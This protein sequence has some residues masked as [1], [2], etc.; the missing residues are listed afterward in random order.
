MLI[1]S[2]KCGGKMSEGTTGTGVSGVEYIQTPDMF[3]NKKN[4]V[5]NN[6]VL[7]NSNEYILG[8]G[9]SEYG[10]S[11][12]RIFSQ[13]KDSEIGYRQS[14]MIKDSDIYKTYIGKK[15]DNIEQT[16]TGLN[17]VWWEWRGFEDLVN[18]NLINM[19]KDENIEDFQQA[20]RGRSGFEKWTGLSKGQLAADIKRMKG[21]AEKWEGLRDEAQRKLMG[22]LNSLVANPDNSIQENFWEDVQQNWRLL[23][24]RYVGDKDVLDRG[25][26]MTVVDKIRSQIANGLYEKN[27]YKT[28][29]TRARFLERE[30]KKWPER[31]AELERK[32][33]EKI[34]REKLGIAEDVKEA[35]ETKPD[36]LGKIVL[37]GEA[38]VVEAVSE[39]KKIVLDEKA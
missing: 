36:R 27:G 6:S 9:L 7:S 3:G 12:F 14:R 2:L 4:K 39:G 5:V 25:L 15:D 1:G 21:E 31:R 30:R 10:R 29:E 23:R 24:E 34:R 20:I 8:E 28:P 22:Q 26:V 18:S 38:E 19:P 32:E 33:E 11:L 13:S 16:L 37:V 17:D 35:V